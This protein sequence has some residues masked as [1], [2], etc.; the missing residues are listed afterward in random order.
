MS[1]EPEPRLD[2]E[3][4]ALFAREGRE[5]GPGVPQAGGAIRECLP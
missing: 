2:D 3:A 1:E 4:L 5:V